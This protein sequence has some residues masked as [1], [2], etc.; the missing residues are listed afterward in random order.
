MALIRDN[1][2]ALLASNLSQYLAGA[3]NTAGT[4]VDTNEL[5]R[6]VNQ[7]LGTGEQISSDI[8]TISNGIY[9]KFGAIDKVTNRTE[10]VTS[11]IWS[12]DTGSLG[13]FYTSSTQLTDVSSKYYIDVYNLNPTTDTSAEVQFSI[14]YGDVNGFGA[15]TLTQDDSST[16]P[17]KAV[18]NQ[19]KNV[20]LDAADSYFSV[21]SGSTLAGH[22]LQ[23][24]YV[25][26]VNRARYKERLDPGNISLDLS[27]SN[28]IITLIDD[29]GGTDENVT[30]A[31]RVYN[32][33]SGSLNIGSALTASIAQ[34]SDTYTKQGYGLFYPDMGIILLNPTA[35]SA[36]VGGTLAPAS[37]SA[38]S[39]YHINRSINFGGLAVLKALEK[40]NDFQARRTENV[41]TS[42]YFVR[43][44][45]REFNFSNNP[46]FVT[47][48][49]GAF[50]NSTFERD[51]K[52]YIT[53]VGLY[54]D[55]NELLAVAKTSKPIEKSFDKEVAIKVK[56]DF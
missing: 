6:I 25:L 37:S 56:L 49:V 1:R 47:G 4:P 46:T 12:G 30:T 55:A 2:G 13:V 32:L 24:F 9:K 38:A 11:G 39:T 29:S 42:H 27:G 20:L 54:D 8:T 50:V 48:S 10:I 21:Y 15:P 40:G 51:P 16:L 7:F 44:N 52:V 45:N 41:S 5:V 22:N 14:A 43:A 18:Y 34:Y 53:T 35:L 33:V 3:A 19:F 36:S 23:N 31:G 28:G 26:N 17:T